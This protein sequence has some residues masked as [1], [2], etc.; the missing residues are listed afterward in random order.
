MNACSA[1]E[2]SSASKPSAQTYT[3]HGLASNPQVA[4]ER[5]RLVVFPAATTQF[6][7]ALDVDFSATRRVQAG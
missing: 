5:M 1:S 6:D 2:R 3:I 7:A 4:H